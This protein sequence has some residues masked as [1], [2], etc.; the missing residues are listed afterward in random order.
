MRRAT[1]AGVVVVAAAGNYSAWTV[2]PARFPEVIA[3]GACDHD[4][5]RW[6]WTS[7]RDPIDVYAPGAGVW[8]ANA[9]DPATLVR[10]GNGTS[11]AAAVTAGAVATWLSFHGRDRL[12]ARFG[13]A[14]LAAAARTALVA[15][16]ARSAMGSAVLDLHALLEQ[17]LPDV[18][19]RSYFGRLESTTDV[20]EDPAP[21]LPTGVAA[22]SPAVAAELGFFTQLGQLRGGDWRALAETHGSPQLKAAL[23]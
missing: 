7:G 20:I 14:G 13:R 11:F 8:V 4:L 12:L 5:R 10:R 2:W 23:G 19:P 21:E 17:A 6:R 16:A 1:D 15:S 18:D 22:P 3:C 9:G